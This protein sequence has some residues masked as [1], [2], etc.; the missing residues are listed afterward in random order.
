VFE[1]NGGTN[2]IKVNCG[3]KYQKSSVHR[4]FIVDKIPSGVNKGEIPENPCDRLKFTYNTEVCIDGI[5][6]GSPLPANKGGAHHTKH[7]VAQEASAD[8]AE[9]DAATSVDP[10]EEVAE[11]R[12]RAPTTLLRLKTSQRGVKHLESELGKLIDI[13]DR[14]EHRIEFQEEVNY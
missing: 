13:V 4:S 1:G 10:S 5:Y 11:I 2:S 12:P 9:T 8:D 14:I 3:D 6:H 7:S